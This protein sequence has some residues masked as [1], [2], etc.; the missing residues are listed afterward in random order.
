VSHRQ[1][2]VSLNVTV[3]PAGLL[4]RTVSTW[5]ST[6]YLP[7]ASIGDVKDAA[8]LAPFACADA[9]RPGSGSPLALPLIEH[10]MSR[11]DH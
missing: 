3:D 9:I 7:G 2:V 5:T 10:D 11:R 8:L 6:D 4:E 1:I